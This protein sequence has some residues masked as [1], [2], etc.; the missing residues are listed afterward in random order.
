MASM[1]ATPLAERSLY[2]GSHAAR[3]LV[4]L[5]LLRQLFD[6]GLLTI[7]IAP[8]AYL[9]ILHILSPV[10]SRP[11]LWAWTGLLALEWVY[12]LGI[13]LWFRRRER[14]VEE[15]PRWLTAKCISTILSSVALSAVGWLVFPPWDQFTHILM[16]FIFLSTAT[17]VTA[18]AFSAF[19]RMLLLY[20]VISWLPFLLQLL[21]STQS[22]AFLLG[23][24][25]LLYLTVTLIYGWGVHRIYHNGVMLQVTNAQLVADLSASKTE[26]ER[27]LQRS[28]GLARRDELTGL[29]NRREMWVRLDT[30]LKLQQ[31]LGQPFCF[32]LLDLDFFKSIN[33][34]HGHLVG[35]EVL[36]T[37]AQLTQGCLRDIDFI[38]RYG[39]EE[40]AVIL[41]QTRLQE[42]EQ[43][44]ERL[45]Q[46][47]AAHS[48][49]VDGQ[50]LRIT[51]SIGLT[52][53][54]T[55]E[56]LNI[57]L[58]RADSALYQAKAAG[59]NQVICDFDVLQPR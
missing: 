28:E 6:Q 34:Q 48:L 27:A 45:R 38:A 56:P 29:Y 37:L 20:N 39:G 59:R 13:T 3:Q 43:S 54:R 5:Q 12:H 14:R 42:A 41:P 10:I 31:R 16:L 57:T 26:L 8:F 51:V 36:R 15:V 1:I 18:V 44:M 25:G 35:D 46:H 33:D 58:A 11:R 30:Q 32:A 19:K 49:Q 21:F 52:Q 4:R 23:I 24:G 2:S 7:F 17:A 55:G 50:S 53:Y 40:F 9:L 22:Q 47:V